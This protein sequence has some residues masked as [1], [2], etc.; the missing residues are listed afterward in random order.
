MDH[1][2]RQKH[3]ASP[4]RPRSRKRALC[5][6]ISL[7]CGALWLSGC[8]PAAEPAKAATPAPAAAPAPTGAGA[9]A[10]APAAPK[11]PSGP[12][13][14]LVKSNLPGAKVEATRTVAA[15]EAAKPPAKGIIGEALTGLPPG[16][17]AVVVKAEGWPDLPSEATLTPGGMT[18]VE[19]N[20]KTGSLNLDSEPS[21]ATVKHGAEVLG[22]TP[23]MILQLP[24]GECPLALEFPPWPA[25]TFKVAITEN[26]EA[27]ATLRLPHGKL[28]LEST[29]AGATVLQGR[30][31]LGQTPLVMERLPAGAFKFTL[32]AKDFPPLETSVTVADR[33]DLVVNRDLGAGFPL[34]DPAALLSSVW[35]EEN[36]DRITENFDATGRHAP[37]N[38]VVKN[39]QRKKLHDNW[40]ERKYRFTAPVRGWN[41]GTGEIEFAEDKNNV[42]RFRVVAKLA[43]NAPVP[44]DAG[45]KDAK[46]AVYGT[47]TGVEEPRWPSRVITLELS[48][49]QILRELP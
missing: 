7:V 14:L 12:G 2:D 42:T 35:M 10:G 1:H 45:G 32:Q 9:T 31:T 28:R 6:L 36:K 5:G 34:L 37:K 17:Y 39:L 29:P 41:R 19:A 13:R 47:L 21:G 24:P 46:L 8:G 30:R 27:T 40:L 49:V 15:G 3:F 20:F 16:T 33:A 25:M 38:G 4:A 23:L 43:P 22:K 48:S 44:A 18:V 11:P 26:Q